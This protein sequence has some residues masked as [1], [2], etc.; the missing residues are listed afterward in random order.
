MRITKTIFV[1]TLFFILGTVS[2][3]ADGETVLAPWFPRNLP[4]GVQ[5]SGAVGARFRISTLVKEVIINPGSAFDFEVDIQAE[6][7]WMFFTPPFIGIAIWSVAKYRT[8]IE[9]LNAKGRAS[10]V[11][12]NLTSLKH[13]TDLLQVQGVFELMQEYF[14][15]SFGLSGVVTSAEIVN[16]LFAKSLNQDE[17]E[18]FAKFFSHIE[19]LK[20]NPDLSNKDCD[21]V[22][23]AIV[24]IRILEVRR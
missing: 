16:G 7:I 23:Q 12:E 5:F 20:F 13:K 2:H 1:A 22:G 4:D 21:I 14:H 19:T 17:A 11:L 3:A 18:R 9:L 24:W 10:W 6:F 15:C 8:S